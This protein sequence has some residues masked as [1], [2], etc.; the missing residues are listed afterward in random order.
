[1][2]RGA[3]RALTVCYCC[4]RPFFCPSGLRP[5]AHTLTLSLQL[6][7]RERQRTLRA[8]FGRTCS[9]PSSSSASRNCKTKKS[10]FVW[11]AA[12]SVQPLRVS[13]LCTI[14]CA[15]CT[16]RRLRFGGI[17]EQRARQKRMI[18]GSLSSNG[19]VC[20]CVFHLQVVSWVLTSPLARAPV[21]VRKSSSHAHSSANTQTRARSHP[22]RTI[23]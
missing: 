14:G 15:K 1:M 20:V 18:G 6:D 11:R 3:N 10:Y 13:C 5:P 7:A 22:L 8:S 17:I 4:L 9:G 16:P 2:I 19:C 23:K 12:Y 21:L